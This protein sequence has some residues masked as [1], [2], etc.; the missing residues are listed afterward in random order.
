MPDRGLVLG[1]AL[2]A[3]GLAAC[4][5]E[6][7]ASGGGSVRPPYASA[8][9]IPATPVR[10]TLRGRPFEARDARV[11]V[12]DRAGYEQVEI[13]LSAASAGAPCGELAEPAPLRVWL[14]RAGPAPVASGEIRLAPGAEQSWELHY[15]LE[16]DGVWIGSAEAA[17]IV[18]LR[19]PDGGAGLAG[20]LAACFADGTGSCVAG[21][22]EALRCPSSLD[23]PLRG[24]EPSEPLPIDAGRG[25]G[26]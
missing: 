26:R 9:E 11:L 20:E 8:D 3:V 19:A 7:S 6:P 24:N 1:A 16:L 23:M 15:Q 14:R 17:A 22:F 18:R 21:R 25:A 13:A 12:D 10:G 5:A 2:L 4:Q